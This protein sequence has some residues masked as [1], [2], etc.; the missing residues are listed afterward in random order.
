MKLV[1]CAHCGNMAIMMQDS[2]VPMICCGEPMGEVKAGVTDAAQEKHVPAVTVDGNTLQVVVG[3]VEHP[4]LEEH[5]I[6]WILC[7]QGDRTQYVKLHPGQP[8]KATFTVEAGKEYR[9]Y[10][11]CNLHGLWMTSGKA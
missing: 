9:V 8:P 6:Q 7:E 3:S 5:Y 2:G 10:E 1:R 4:M 11:Y